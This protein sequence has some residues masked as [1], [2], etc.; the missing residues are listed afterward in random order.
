MEDEDVESVE[1]RG[2]SEVGELEI[3]KELENGT[4]GELEDRAVDELEDRLVDELDRAVDELELEVEVMHG[5]DD[6]LD[7]EFEGIFTT[8][9]NTS[10][11]NITLE[12]VGSSGENIKIADGTNDSPFKV[13]ESCSIRFGGV[14]KRLNGKEGSFNAPLMNVLTS[15]IVSCARNLPSK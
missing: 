9:S 10:F 7:E 14:T 4:M 3:E 15:P 13:A 8:A 11:R 1:D 2:V 6:E 5:L 12:L